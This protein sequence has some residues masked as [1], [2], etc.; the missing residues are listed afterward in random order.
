MKARA[1]A[2]PEIRVFERTE[3]KALN[4]IPNMSYLQRKKLAQL[5]GDQYNMHIRSRIKAKAKFGSFSPNL[6]VKIELQI[7]ETGQIIYHEIKESSGS[8]AFDQA[9]ILAV[10]NAV[11]DALPKALAENPPYIVL[12][13]I[14]SPQN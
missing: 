8:K 2:V 9:A 5:A 7:D 11:L 1:V 3:D 12:I 6:F 10:R 14:Q 4:Q 13:R